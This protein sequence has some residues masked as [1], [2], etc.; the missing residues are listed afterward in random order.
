[1]YIYIYIILISHQKS[2][3]PAIKDVWF[4]VA[5]LLQDR[6]QKNPSIFKIILKYFCGNLKHWHKHRGVKI[7]IKVVF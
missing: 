4:S 1:M 6:K 3:A 2:A 7:S 5:S